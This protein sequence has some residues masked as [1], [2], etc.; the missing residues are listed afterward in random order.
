MIGFDWPESCEFYD[1]FEWSLGC[2]CHKCKHPDNKYGCMPV[3]CPM[4]EN[5]D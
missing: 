2:Q 1:G 4:R 5:N 3:A